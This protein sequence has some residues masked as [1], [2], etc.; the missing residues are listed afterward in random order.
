MNWPEKRRFFETFY[1]SVEEK[2]NEISNYLLSKTNYLLVY[3]VRLK[4]TKHMKHI[5]L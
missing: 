4:Q 2:G 3:N 1:V 5:S